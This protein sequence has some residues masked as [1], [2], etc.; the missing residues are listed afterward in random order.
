MV[1]S[2]SLPPAAFPTA[3]RYPPA[4]TLINSNK[5]ANL[6]KID[7]FLVSP[8]R[9]SPSFFLERFHRRGPSLVSISEDEDG[10]LDR[11]GYSYDGAEYASQPVAVTAAA[12][13]AVTG[14][15]TS[16]RPPVHP[17]RPTAQLGHRRQRCELFLLLVVTEEGVTHSSLLCVSLR[18]AAV[19]LL[20]NLVASYPST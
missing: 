13:A 17:G 14:E 8:P 15:D 19:M 7:F 4:C 18:V 12:T 16:G 11:G 6:T 5:Y 3:A 20:C 2:P 10:Y 1:S 9:P